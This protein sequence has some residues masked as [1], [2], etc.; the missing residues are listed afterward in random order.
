MRIISEWVGTIKG[1]HYVCHILPRGVASSHTSYIHEYTC[2]QAASFLFFFPVKMRQESVFICPI[3]WWS[4]H[5]GVSERDRSRSRLWTA[6]HSARTHCMHTH[7]YCLSVVSCARHSKPFSHL[8]PL[9][10]CIQVVHHERHD[11]RSSTDTHSHSSEIH[12][13]THT[14]SWNELAWFGCTGI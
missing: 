4:R 7:T 5:S 1:L 14:H 11:P 10:T 9:H 8:K 2:T 3:D 13:I 6:S 12:N